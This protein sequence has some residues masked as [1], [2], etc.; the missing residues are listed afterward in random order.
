MSLRACFVGMAS[1]IN[2]SHV[3]GTESIVRRLL[4]AGQDSGAISFEVVLI[5]KKSEYQS[6]HKGVRYFDNLNEAISYFESREG[7]DIII[8][9]YLPFFERL[10]F[11]LY[12]LRSKKR[13]YVI[14][15][16]W[17]RGVK[18]LSLIFDA[19]IYGYNGG[20]IC[21]SKRQHDFLKKFFKKVFFVLPP[22]PN[23]YFQ[24]MGKLV[25]KDYDLVFVG[26]LDLS[27]GID[28]VVDVFEILLEKYPDLN[29]AI[30]GIRF[31]GDDYSRSMHEYLLSDNCN[32]KYYPVERKNYST[33][34]EAASSEVLKRAKVFVQPYNNVY[35]TIDSPLL[36]LEAMAS[37]CV[38]L[39]SQEDN[40]KGLYG[41]SDL[42]IPSS[43]ESV[44]ENLLLSAEK[45]LFSSEC[46]SEEIKR[47]TKQVNSLR[48]KSSE[49]LS[50]Y[51]KIFNNRVI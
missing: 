39:T 24:D 4:E 8:K 19:I 22:V 49:V 51:V 45:M 20:I 40:L 25:K 23:T 21:I 12:R 42:Y 5:G 32:I 31:S 46:Y 41:D 29:I 18:R 17:G 3:G 9:M 50:D 6:V 10:K 13:F 15:T 11:L 2:L 28:I 36:V 44:R 47:C 38:V 30:Y 48:F 7:M 34:L 1:A 33:E 16:S 37:G 14:L 26:R 43:T 35:G 27:K